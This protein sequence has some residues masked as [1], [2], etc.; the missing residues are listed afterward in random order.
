MRR[1][2][3]WLSKLPLGM[4]M[5]A[6]VL[7]AGCK[8][9][10]DGP[11]SHYVQ[12]TIESIDLANGMVRVRSYSEKHKQEMFHDVEVTKDTEVKINGAIAKLTDVK[13][14]ENAEGHITV[15]KEDN[16]R[17]FIADRV[18]IERAEALVAP[19]AKHNAG[20][21][22]TDNDSNGEDSGMDDDSSDD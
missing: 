17:R 6:A 2:E 12:G 8:E 9:E 14:G 5:I 19:K 3:W 13:V 7:P 11:K 22:A 18:S 21:K 20:D 1:S 15:V 16:Q 4:L 10:D